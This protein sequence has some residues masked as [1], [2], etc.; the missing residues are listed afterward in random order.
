MEQTCSFCS[1]LDDLRFWAL[2]P[3]VIYLQ[4]AAEHGAETVPIGAASVR[5][6]FLARRRGGMPWGSFGRRQLRG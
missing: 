3:L 6:L 4:V 1:R 2:E 5:G